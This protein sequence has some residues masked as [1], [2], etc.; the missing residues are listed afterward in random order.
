MY[1]QYHLLGNFLPCLLVV[2]VPSVFRNLRTVKESSWELGVET[3]LLFSVDL[4]A[5]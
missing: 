4:R 3:A 5:L 1:E 2:S